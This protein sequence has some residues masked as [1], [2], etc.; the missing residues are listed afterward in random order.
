MI[1]LLAVLPLR[2]TK[3][4]EKYNAGMKAND[5]DITSLSMTNIVA[6]RG[7][8]FMDGN[9]TAPRLLRSR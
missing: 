9:I 2:G 3:S 1:A 5:G 6:L 4:I 7:M 8:K